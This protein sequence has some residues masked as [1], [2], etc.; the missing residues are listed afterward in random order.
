LT[1]EDS[2]SSSGPA[3]RPLQLVPMS[4]ETA[5]ALD[6]LSNDLANFLGSRMDLSLADIAYSSATQRPASSHR[7]FALCKDC[8]DAALVLQMMDSE[9]LISARPSGVLPEVVFMFAGTGAQHVNMG[10]QL[11]DT[12]KVFRDAVDECTV[13]LQLALDLDI[14][15]LLYPPAGRRDEDHK[16]GFSDTATSLLV[17]FVVEYALAQLL[18]AWGLFPKAMIGNSSGEY[19]AACLAGVFSLGDALRI[20]LFRGNLL[21]GLPKGSMLVVYDSQDRVQ[22][23]LDERTWITSVHSA[24]VCIVAGSPEAIAALQERLDEAVIDFA[25]IEVE[26]AGHSPMIEPALPKFRDFLN[27]VQF[28][29]PTISFVSNLTGNW[30]GNE[31]TR[32]EYWVDHLRSTVHLDAGLSTLLKECN[33]IF[34]DVGPGRT[35]TSLVRSHSDRRPSQL[36]LPCM[37][38]PTDK[39]SDLEILLDAIGRVWLAGCDIDWKAFY[40]DGQRHTSPGDWRVKTHTALS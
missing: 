9:R 26:V 38:H 3:V 33:G 10:R 1:W 32:P 29:E 36:V 19:V 12:E 4:A 34:V 7:R 2:R 5:K 27:S 13:L 22:S 31:V 23:F 20:V 39:R 6:S 28:G 16:R 30:A 8:K 35:L 40:G 37:R 11:Y 21:D 25:P 14:R 17:L 15:T 24:S 18:M